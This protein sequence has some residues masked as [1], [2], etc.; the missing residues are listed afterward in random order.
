MFVMRL[1]A[2]PTVSAR[3]ATSRSLPTVRAGAAVAAV[4]A[5]LPRITPRAARC[6]RTRRKQEETPI[7]I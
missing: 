6:S 1:T 4:G 7:A 3:V 5:A 2:S